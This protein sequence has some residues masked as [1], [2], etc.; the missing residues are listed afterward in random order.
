M[1]LKLINFLLGLI[2]PTLLKGTPIMKITFIEGN[3]IQDV[4]LTPEDIKQLMSDI[5]SI[6][7]M[8]NSNP[9]TAKSLG[10]LVGSI[11]KNI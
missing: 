11:M 7:E 8:L 6:L 5:R 2:V 9:T 4:E 1:K 3:V 10:D